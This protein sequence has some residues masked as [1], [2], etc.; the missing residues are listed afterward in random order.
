M[1]FLKIPNPISRREKSFVPEDSF[2]SNDSSQ[3][4]RAAVMVQGEA[5]VVQEVDKEEDLEEVLEVI[6]AQVVK[7]LVEE[8]GR[9]GES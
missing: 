4:H 1:N 3:I 5:E 7:A 9:R 2:V 8:R 6:R